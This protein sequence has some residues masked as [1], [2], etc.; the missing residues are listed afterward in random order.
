MIVGLLNETSGSA[1]GTY[2]ACVLA[3]VPAG[4][5]WLRVAQRE[6]YIAD[7]ASRFALRWWTSEPANLA[8]GAVALAGV[9]IGGLWPLAALATVAVAV[10]GPL[11]LSVHGR[12]SPLVLTRRL[13]TLAGVWVL[14]EGV[15]LGV[16]AGVGAPVPFAAA[17]LV[18]APALVDAALLVTAPFERRA[19]ERFVE[20]A[21]DRLRRVAPT[22][23]AVTGS[24]GKTSTKNHIAHLVAGS[25]SVVATPASF[26]NRG[27]LARAVNEHLAEGTDVFVAEMGTY[28]PGEIRDLCRWCPPQISVMTAVG[29]VHLERFGSEDAILAAKSEITEGAATVVVNADDRRLAALGSV[30][31]AAKDGPQVVRAA[32]EDPNADVRVRVDGERVTVVVDGVVA[33]APVTLRPGIQPSNLACAVAVALQLDVPL[34]AVLA[35]IPTLPAVANRLT[36]DTSASGVHVIDDT[37]NSNP[38]GARAALALL[39]AAAAAVDGRRVLVT[40]GMVELGA[41][42]A[43]ENET[44]AQAACEVVSTLVVVGL[45]N[46]RA[47]LRGAAGLVPV[48]VVRT[49]SEAVAWVRANLG[50]G[51]AVL[52]ENDLPDHYP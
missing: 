20:R 8:L 19:S 38:A 27:G 39:A 11:H 41:R 44:L 43:S 40:P 2:G 29:P 21:A 35:R 47:L 46:R 22:I 5:R 25:K 18:A 52:Y 3:L 13:K 9:V 50:P 33:G 7:S 4:A 31:D 48:V 26:N 51:D 42:Q 37:F 17:G 14:C 34:D 36:A 16:G 12:T 23:V 6:H 24:Y 28:G 30:L 1:W 15:L 45:T 32:V 49:R 10:V